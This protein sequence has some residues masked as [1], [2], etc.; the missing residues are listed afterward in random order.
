MQP[1]IVRTVIQNRQKDEALVYDINEE[2][3]LYERYIIAI[4]Y[5]LNARYDNVVQQEISY[6]QP[7]PFCRGHQRDMSHKD[8]VDKL[9]VCC[10][11]QIS[12]QMLVLFHNPHWM[13]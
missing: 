12:V 13:E 6:S 1:S 10:S 8:K 7:L 9:V 4:E 2:S 5:V 3:P 11:G